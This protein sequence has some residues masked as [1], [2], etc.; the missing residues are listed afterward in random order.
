ML[1]TGEK[2]A[3]YSFFSV[4]LGLLAMTMW[5]YMPQHLRK[6]ASRAE[7]YVS[8]EDPVV[9]EAEMIGLEEAVTTF[10]SAAVAA[11]GGGGVEGAATLGAGQGE[12]T[13]LSLMEGYPGAP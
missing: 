13:A 10:L 5:I 11:V 9:K 12:V 8:G 1:T 7:Y 6:V 3:F 2:I 4:S